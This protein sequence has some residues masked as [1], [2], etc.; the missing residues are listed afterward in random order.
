MSTTVS[1]RSAQRLPV[2]AAAI[3]IVKVLFRVPVLVILTPPVAR[4][5]GEAGS[6]PVMLMIAAQTLPAWLSWVAEFTEVQVADPTAL[7][8]VTVPAAT[9]LPGFSV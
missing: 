1:S 5:A 8:W 6:T 3:C 7:L 4:V 2:G 9:V